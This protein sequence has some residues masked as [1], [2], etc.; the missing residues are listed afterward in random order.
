MKPETILAKASDESDVFYRYALY[1]MDEHP[2]ISLPLLRECFK[3]N[4]SA[5][6]YRAGLDR[7]KNGGAGQPNL[8]ANVVA[9]GR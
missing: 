2:T 8:A 6:E 1:M 7:V 3:H 4:A 9:V 5:S